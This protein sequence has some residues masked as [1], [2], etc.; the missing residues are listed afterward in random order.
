MAVPETI[1]GVVVDSKAQ[2]ESVKGVLLEG[3]ALDA[4]FDVKGAGT[5]V[6]AVTSKRLILGD[7]AAPSDLGHV[8]SVPYGRVYWVHAE[9]GG[10]LLGRDA[11]RLIVEAAGTKIE[12]ELKGRDG[13]RRAHDLI[14]RRLL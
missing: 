14:L 11:S 9:V 1:D 8:T 3:E 10:G 12:L 6:L 5:T 7:K 4:V 2:L 13:A